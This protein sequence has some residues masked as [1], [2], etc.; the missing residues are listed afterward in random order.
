MDE[1]MDKT[2]IISMNM[3]AFRQLKDTED[4]RDYWKDIAIGLANSGFC[5]FCESR[6]ATHLI[7]CPDEDGWHRAYSKLPDEFQ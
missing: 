4:E 7:N 6:A 2:K 1:R 3:L 5:E